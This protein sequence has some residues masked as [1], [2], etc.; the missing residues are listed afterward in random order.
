MTIRAR[1]G[2]PARGTPSCAGTT[3]GAR[4]RRRRAPSPWRSSPTSTRRSCATSWPS[5]C[6]PGSAHRAVVCELRLLHDVLIPA[7]EVLRLRGENRGPGHRGERLARHELTAAPLLGPRSSSSRR[8]RRR[9][10]R[11][12]AAALEADPL[13]GFIGA[14][15]HD[16]PAAAAGCRSLDRQNFRPVRL[17]L[18]NELGSV[19]AVRAEY[20]V[21][22]GAG[23]TPALVASLLLATSATGDPTAP[24]GGAE[25]PAR[26]AEHKP[27][28]VPAEA[29]LPMQAPLTVVALGLL[30]ALVL[31][32]I[33]LNLVGVRDICGTIPQCRQASFASAGEKFGHR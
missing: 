14:G 29:A 22:T 20:R 30:R 31:D 26:R 18:W 15:S 23:V 25:R 11:T 32:R 16:G 12:S 7:G 27:A 2:P 9:T 4:H 33:G 3:A 13:A 8:P 21:H 19:G 10:L 5:P 28:G 6:S 24:V 1:C 17:S